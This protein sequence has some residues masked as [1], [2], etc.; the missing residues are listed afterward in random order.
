MSFFRDHA[1]LFALICGGVAVGFGVYLT[2]W[3]MRRPKGSERM[4]EISR[5]VQEGAAAYL[6]PVSYTHLTLPTNREV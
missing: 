5:A 1:V 2:A 6:S 4:Q 3:L